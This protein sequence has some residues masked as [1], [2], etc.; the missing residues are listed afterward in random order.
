[1]TEL[2]DFAELLKKRAMAF[3]KGKKTGVPDID[4]LLTGQSILKLTMFYTL[5]D[6][7][8]K[9]FNEVGRR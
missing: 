8:L 5:I 4:V 6:E 1:M 9:E 7:T 2:T 3:E